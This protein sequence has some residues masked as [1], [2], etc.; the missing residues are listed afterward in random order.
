MLILPAEASD[1]RRPWTLEY[2]HANVLATN[3]PTRTALTVRDA[4]DSAV[5]NGFHKAVAQN[6]Q[7]NPQSLPE[8]LIHF[9]CVRR[10]LLCVWTDGQCVHQ[11]TTSN[12]VESVINRY[13][14]IKEVA[15]GIQAPNA[16]FGHMRPPAR[17]RTLMAVHAGFLVVNRTE[18]VRE[19]LLLLKN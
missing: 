8:G 2:R 11:R 4:D 1:G 9:E 10:N 7:G 19:P 17:D 13:R 6:V 3:G 12:L 16:E 15:G 14:G 18:P 5:G